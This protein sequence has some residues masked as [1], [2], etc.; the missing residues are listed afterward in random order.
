VL[1]RQTI[2]VVRTILVA[3]LPLAVVL[4]AKP[5][6]HASPGMF[7]WALIAT[8]TWALLY[9]VLSLDPAIRDQ[10]DTANQVVEF[11]TRQ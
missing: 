6:L 11:L 10:I 3:A 8:G 1:R 7:G 5:L 4:A 2:T 9:V